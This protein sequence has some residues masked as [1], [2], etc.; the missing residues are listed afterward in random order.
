[1][2][3]SVAGWGR[4]MAQSMDPVAGST[5]MVA[6]GSSSRAGRGRRFEGGGMAFA[7][8]DAVEV[9]RA[10]GKGRGVFARRAI[11]KGEVFERVPILFL[12]REEYAKGV[13]GTILGSYCFAWEGDRVALALGYGSIYN[14][15]YRPNAR[16]DDI[17]D[18]AKEFT[19]LRAIEP[20][21]EITI[22]YNGKPRSRAKVWFDVVEPD[23]AGKVEA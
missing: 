23:E 11:R 5:A 16:Y 20:G 3:C 8:S 22:N 7:Q 2:G 15:S 4:A 18:R 13:D 6:V 21:E 17:G 10:P 14:H 19:A 1:V 9:K 12:T